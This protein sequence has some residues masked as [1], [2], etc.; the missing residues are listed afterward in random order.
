MRTAHNRRSFLL[1]GVGMVA[2]PALAQTSDYAVFSEFSP[3]SK[4]MQPGWNRRVFTTTEARKGNA[5]ECDLATG[6]V[7]LAPGTWHLSGYSMVVYDDPAT[8]AEMAPVRSPAAAGYCRLRT[9]D[10]AVAV[11]PANLIAIRNDDPT[12]LC[13]GSPST[14]NMTPSLFDAYY[15]A[16]RSTQIVLEHQAGASPDGIYLRIFR[17]GSSWHAFA[18]INI[19][20]LG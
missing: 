4:K 1:G 20:R 12:V 17:Q 10:P 13:V 14:A 2:S 8:S 6:V 16:R 15:E 18:R 19:R 11:D 7:T 3:E 9:F 5:I